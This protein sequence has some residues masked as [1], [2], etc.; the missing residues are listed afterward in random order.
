MV[1]L[2]LF[3]SFQNHELFYRIFAFRI[4]WKIQNW[5]NNKKVMIKTVIFFQLCKGGLSWEL[6]SKN[7]ID[8][9]FSK[10]KFTDIIRFPIFKAWY[11]ENLTL[12]DKT[13]AKKS[14]GGTF[15]KTTPYIMI[16]SQA[17]GLAW[18]TLSRYNSRRAL[19]LD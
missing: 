8:K 12:I 17:I 6:E 18:I 3:R 4:S 7:V 2:K 19:Y 5:L 14:P 1:L 11:H 13:T 16:G 9:I 10:S 15:E